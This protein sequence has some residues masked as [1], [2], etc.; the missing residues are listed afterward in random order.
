MGDGFTSEINDIFL[1]FINAYNVYIILCMDI[2]AILYTCTASV[3]KRCCVL[4]T[5]Y[6]IHSP[7]LNFCTKYSMYSM[8][9]CRA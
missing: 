4:L 6:P 2:G 1:Y 7:S 3:R 9:I 5:Y 8:E